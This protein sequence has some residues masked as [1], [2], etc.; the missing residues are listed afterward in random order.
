MFNATQTNPLSSIGSISIYS[1]LGVPMF[2]LSVCLPCSF[3]FQLIPIP[4]SVGFPSIIPQMSL[5]HAPNINQR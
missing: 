3:P 2:L 4:F 5:F 1:L